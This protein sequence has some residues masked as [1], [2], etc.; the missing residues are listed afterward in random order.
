MQSQNLLRSHGGPILPAIN[1]N[2]TSAPITGFNRPDTTQ[3]IPFKP[4][5]DAR[6]LIFL[7][8]KL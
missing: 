5:Q 4:L 2:E 6:K 8:S 3:M 1:R 7:K